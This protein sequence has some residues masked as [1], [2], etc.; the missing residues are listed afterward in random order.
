MTQLDKPILFLATTNAERARTFYEHDYGYPQHE[1]LACER[2]GRIIEFQSPVLDAVIRD[3][4]GGQQF[5][6]SGYTLIVR[7]TCV[8]C[9][10][11][12]SAKRRLDLI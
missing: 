2:C 6:S 10:R 4:C 5:Q 3:A 12:M 9:N 7:G 11:A 1:H 8:E